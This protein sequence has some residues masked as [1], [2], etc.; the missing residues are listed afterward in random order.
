MANGVGSACGLDAESVD[1]W[2]GGTCQRG[3]PEGDNV[4]VSNPYV[5]PFGATTVGT[6]C[7]A[8]P[9]TSVVNI[10][11]IPLPSPLP[12]SLLLPPP[13][14][15]HTTPH[16]TTLPPPPPPSQP[17]QTIPHYHTTSRHT[18]PHQPL[19]INNQPSCR[20]APP[21]FAKRVSTDRA[22]AHISELVSVCEIDKVTRLSA[23]EFVA[24]VPA[25]AQTRIAQNTCCV[26]A[27]GSSVETNDQIRP[28]QT[29]PDQTRPD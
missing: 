8:V 18:A 24:E 17:H 15:H 26:R 5:V 1:S 23:K 13:P 29:R 25:H 16:Y 7:A 22:D 3:G 11:D 20:R 28:D 27:E 6:G 14:P 19:I 4:T 12:S 21:G 9:V 10:L 2:V